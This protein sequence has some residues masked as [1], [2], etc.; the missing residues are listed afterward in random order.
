MFAEKE[1]I[2]SGV[3]CRIGTL[4]NIEII[5]QPWLTDDVN[6]CLTSVFTVYRAQNCILPYMPT[7]EIEI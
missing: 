4:E 1:V 7:K 6:P 3:K 5:G 2:L